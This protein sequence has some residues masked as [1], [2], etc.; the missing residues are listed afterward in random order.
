GYF[1]SIHSLCNHI[2]LGDFNWLKRFSKLRPFGY[3]RQ[4]LFNQDLSFTSIVFETIGDYLTKREDLDQYLLEFVNELL[5]D[6]LGQYLEYLDGKGNLHRRLFGGLVL[7]CFNHQTHHRG[8]ISIYLDSLGIN[9]DFSSL[10]G[11]V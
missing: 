2:Y 6:D 5:E 7:H 4:A 10:A 9:N 3:S 8:M 11:M 1:N